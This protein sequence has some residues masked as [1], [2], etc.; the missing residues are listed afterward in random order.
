[1][2]HVHVH[3]HVHVGMLSC[4]VYTSILACV[5][6]QACESACAWYRLP[7]RLEIAPRLGRRVRVDRAAVANGVQQ[8]VLGDRGVRV[9]GP[10]DREEAGV[11]HRIVANMWF[12]SHVASIGLGSGLDW[13]WIDHPRLHFRHVFPPRPLGLG[14]AWQPQ[15]MRTWYVFTHSLRTAYLCF[16]FRGR[17][18]EDGAWI[19][20]GLAI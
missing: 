9:R 12:F 7:A 10:L 8:L 14:L 6:W 19:G 5:W 18:S 2:L 20:L 3:V 11:R 4:C 16:R 15:Y 17:F 1:M 13:T